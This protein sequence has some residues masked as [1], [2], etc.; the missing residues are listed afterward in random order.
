MGMPNI[1]ENPSRDELT[2]IGPMP[3]DLPFEVDE[4]S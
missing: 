2:F 1:L 3:K 4:G